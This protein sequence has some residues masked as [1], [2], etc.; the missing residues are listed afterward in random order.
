M[1][2]IIITKTNGGLGRTLIERDFI[3]G[4][5]MYNANLPTSWGTD[6]VKAYSNL[7]E[8]EADGI[9]KGSTNWSYEWYH[10][11]EYFRI[12]PDGKIYLYLSPDTTPFD[13]N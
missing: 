3:S 11:S 9:T 7:L 8:A 6:K 5:L 13:Y 1:S 2:G 4:L 12:Q 10:I